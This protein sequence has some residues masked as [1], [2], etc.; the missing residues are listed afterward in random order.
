LIVFILACHF[1]FYLTAVVASAGG[2]SVIRKCDPPVEQSTPQ[3][4][5]LSTYFRSP[6]PTRHAELEFALVRNLNNSNIHT[7]HL[8]IE[9]PHPESILPQ[10]HRNRIHIQR[11]QRQPFYSDLFSY[12]NEH[13]MDQIVIIQNVDIYWTE[14]SMRKLFHTLDVGVVFA[15]SRHSNISSIPETQ[16][17]SNATHDRKYA[18][19]TIIFQ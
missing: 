11:T 17:G 18:I 5:I 4:H 16:C 15:L 1:L 12:A 14:E 7:V 8:F 6:N 2:I 9:S 3:I 10:I 13:L 19:K